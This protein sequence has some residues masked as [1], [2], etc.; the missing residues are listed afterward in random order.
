MLTNELGALAGRIWRRKILVLLLTLLFTAASWYSTQDD[1]TVYTSRAALTVMSQNRAPEQDAIL[2]QGY[3]AFF[4]DEVYQAR[5]RQQAGVPDDVTFEATTG[6]A[7]PLLYVS[8]TSTD[9][10]H[11]ATAAGAM[12][13]ALLEEVNAAIQTTH[14]QEVADLRAE[15]EQLRATTGR[16]PDQVIVDLHDRIGEIVADS[17]NKLQAVQLDSTVESTAPSRS[18]TLVLGLLQRAVRRLHPGHAPRRRLPS[19]AVGGRSRTC[20]GCRGRGAAPELP[21]TRRRRPALDHPPTGRGRARE[22]ASARR[23]ERRP[24][25]VVLRLCG[26]LSKTAQG[27]EEG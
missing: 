16:V 23:T 3:A 11:V 5:L 18:I 8:A 15:F 22:H 21:G 12:A 14:R 2:S 7:S 26:H 13:D 17:S 27:R 10:D 6:L 4:N 25:V 20:H 24:A 1:V 9:P 19:G